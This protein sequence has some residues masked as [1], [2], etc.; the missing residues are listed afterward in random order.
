MTAWFDIEISYVRVK[1]TKSVVVDLLS[2]WKATPENIL[3]LLSH[4][5]PTSFLELDNEI[6]LRASRN[7][8]ESK[9]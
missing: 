4:D 5:V 8:P 2:R 1:G 6:L 3:K 7:S 9:D